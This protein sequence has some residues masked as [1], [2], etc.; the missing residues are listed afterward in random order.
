MLSCYVPFVMTTE[1]RA[2]IEMDHIQG[3]AKFFALAAFAAWVG[4]TVASGGAML[5]AS[6]FAGFGTVCGCL[7]VYRFFRPTDP[8]ADR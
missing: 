6:V 2:E 5:V 4:M 1:K 8:A 3:A 7:H